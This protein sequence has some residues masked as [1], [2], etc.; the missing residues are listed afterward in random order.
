MD[1]I[2][3]NEIG[4]IREEQLCRQVPLVTGKDSGGTAGTTVDER[5]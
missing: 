5:V 4:R 3:L 2:I 1:L